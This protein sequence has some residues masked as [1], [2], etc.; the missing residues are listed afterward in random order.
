MFADPEW[1]DRI[2]GR[3]NVLGVHLM[4]PTGVTLRVICETEP[5]SQFNVEREYRLRVLRA[6]EANGIPLATAVPIRPTSAP[7]GPPNG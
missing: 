7:E 2:T 4:D 6:F 1:S 3:P 5:A